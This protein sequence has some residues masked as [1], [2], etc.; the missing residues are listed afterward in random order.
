M[1]DAGVVHHHVEAAEAGDGGLHQ[2]LHLISTGDIGPVEQGAAAVLRDQR[3]GGRAALDHILRDVGDHHMRPMAGE[4][5]GDG[6]ADAGCAAGDDADASRKA[7]RLDR[8]DFGGCGHGAVSRVS[9]GAP[10]ASHHAR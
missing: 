10:V 7:W 8:R 2:R 9:Q 4:Q 1:A 6:A 5:A 3:S